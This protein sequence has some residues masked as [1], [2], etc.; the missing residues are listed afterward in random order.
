MKRLASAQKAQNNMDELVIPPD[1]VVGAEEE[2]EEEG[3]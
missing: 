1:Y 3:Y 2:A